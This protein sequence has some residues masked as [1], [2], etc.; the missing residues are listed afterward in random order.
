MSKDAA[1]RFDDGGA[2]GGDDVGFVQLFTHGNAPLV[3]DDSVSGDK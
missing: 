2:G 1:W 3:F